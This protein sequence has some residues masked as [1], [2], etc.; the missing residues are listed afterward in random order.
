MRADFASRL[1][2]RM[3]VG[4]GELPGRVC[5]W[6]ISF[7]GLR[8]A[9]RISSPNSV[10]RPGVDGSWWLM[11]LAGRPGTALS[12]LP[13]RLSYRYQ[14]CLGGRSVLEPLPSASLTHRACDRRAL[15]PA[16]GS[17]TVD[18]RLEPRKRD[19]EECVKLG[20]GDGCRREEEDDGSE[21]IV[22]E[23]DELKG[24]FRRLVG[25]TGEMDPELE[26]VADP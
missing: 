24:L 8:P 3:S 7:R 6:D 21:V 19:E 13:P 11:W 12:A 1:R 26:V 18:D 16:P 17:L 22:D 2:N 9:A 5:P 4:E 25:I 10:L 14:F 15:A 20:W 23:A